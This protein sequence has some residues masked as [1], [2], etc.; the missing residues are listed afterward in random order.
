[1]ILSTLSH[2]LTTER[3]SKRA[4]SGV[5]FSTPLMSERFLEMGVEPLLITN[6]KGV[7]ISSR[8][9]SEGLVRS[10]FSLVPLEKEDQ[11]LSSLFWSLR[12]TSEKFGWG[13]R[14]SSVPQAIEGMKEKGSTPKTLVV[15]T[16]LTLGE[17]PVTG[18]FGEITIISSSILPKDCALVTADPSLLGVYIRVGDY[19]S[20]QLYRVDQTTSVVSPDAMVR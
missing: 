5:G 16:S 4:S 9:G 19:L 6:T 20:V 17:E 12:S 13:N 3:G 2:L 18:K 8:R 14:Y 1:M 15:S 7:F 11:V 10:G